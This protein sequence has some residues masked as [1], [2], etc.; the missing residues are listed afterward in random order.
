M[1]PACWDIFLQSYAVLATKNP[2]T[3]DLD[4]LGDI[5]ANQELEGDGQGFRPDWSK[6]YAG[7]N[8][9]YSDGWAWNEELDGSEVRLLLE[10]SDEWDF[11]VHDP[12]RVTGL[13]EILNNPPLLP[14]ASSTGDTAHTQS[15]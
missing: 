1:H 13:D 14:L 6:D 10:N 7:A 5:L 11:I 12:E 8:L 3:P 4:R 2:L 15:K 9:F